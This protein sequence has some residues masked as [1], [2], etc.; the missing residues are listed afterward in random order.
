MGIIFDEGAIEP[1]KSV[2]KKMKGEFKV[3][4]FSLDQYAH[5]DQFEDMGDFISLS[6]IPEVI[7]AVYRRIFK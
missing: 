6:P 5:N 3:Y 2:A 7:L 1:F 4:V